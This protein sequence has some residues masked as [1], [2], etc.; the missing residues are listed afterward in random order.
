ML[1]E[2]EK[3][4]ELL[5]E[6][7]EY[8]K[9]WATEGMQTSS[10]GTIRSMF[11]LRFEILESDSAAVVRDKL[12]S[13]MAAAIETE[14]ADLIGHL[15]GFDLPAS[16]VVRKALESEFF[17]ERALA[18]VVNYFQS[19]AR[20]P[21]VIILEDMHWADDSSLDLVNYLS[22]ALPEAHLLLI[23]CLARPALFERRPNWGEGQDTHTHLELK[24]LSRRQSRALVAE[25]LKKVDDIPWDLRNL[26]VDG[27]EG[28]PFYIEELIKML[29]DD[30]VIRNGEDG[31]QIE[32]ERLKE[33]KVPT[34][35][36]GV[37]QAR[38]DSL[39][40]EERAVL[41]RASVIG[42]QF[43]DAAV[44]KLSFDKLEDL[45]KS[46]LGSLLDLSAVVNWSTGVSVLPLQTQMNISSNMLC[47]EM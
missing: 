7:V 42:R 36:A 44:A 26:I 28:N 9:G 13:R 30:G 43:W 40:T 23:I 22:K 38:L 18:S 6:G 8:F 32:L 35:L 29:I 11:A 10:F 21:T 17:K 1:Y 41:Q 24:A 34:T 45:D 31:W 37:I 2:F 39:P 16:M 33:T 3:W 20:K 15:I 46:I 27:A 19:V 47:Y 25:I 14:Q 4:L 12:R 5:S